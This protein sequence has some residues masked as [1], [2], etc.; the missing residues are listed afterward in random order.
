MA[1]V[2]GNWPHGPLPRRMS[3]QKKLLSHNAARRRSP[4][5]QTRQLGRHAPGMGHGRAHLRK[6]VTRQRRI[7]EK[8]MPVSG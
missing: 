1:D 6:T 3:L 8:A 7:F 5:P 4:Q 2:I